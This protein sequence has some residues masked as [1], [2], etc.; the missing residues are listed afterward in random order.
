MKKTLKYL[1]ISVGMVATIGLVACGRND[2]GGTAVSTAAPAS[3]PSADAANKYVGTYDGMCDSSPVLEQSTNLE[4]VQTSQ[5]ILTKIDANTLSFV[6]TIKIYASGT[7]FSCSGAVLATHTRSNT[8][9]IDG[10]SSATQGSAK[11][12]MDKITL[13]L[14]ARDDGKVTPNGVLIYGGD[15]FTDTGIVKTGIYLG[16]NTLYFGEVERSQDRQF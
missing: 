16:D 1:W 7:D 5:I 9:T 6:R 3:A 12:T 4:A 11:V 2:G 15:Y 14:K 8:I 13:T 10:Q